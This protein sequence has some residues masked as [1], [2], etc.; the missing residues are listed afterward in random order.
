M[1]LNLNLFIFK[2][3]KIYP[4]LL[5]VFVVLLVGCNK[6]DVIE[7]NIEQKP[8][9][10]LD[11]EDGVYTVK[12]GHEL[13]IA[14]EYKNIDDAIITWTLDDRIVCRAPEWTATWYDAGE[15]FVTLT[16]FNDAGVAEEEIKVDVVELTPPVISLRLPSEGLKVVANTD[17]AI[18]PDIQHDDMDGFKIAWYVDNKLVSE[19]KEYTFHQS[20]LGTYH[21]KI[22][23][24]NIDGAT[25][26]EFDIQ[27][28][29]TMPYKVEFLTPSYFIKGTT[30]Y[31]F[32][33]RPVFLRPELEY[34]DDPVF[35]WS[36]DGLV[37]D[38]TTQMYEFT[39]TS[40]GEYIVTVTVR[41]GAGNRS[42][43]ITNNVSRAETSVTAEVKVVC[44]DATEEERMR[45][46]S[47]SSSLY[48]NKVYEYTPAPGQFIGETSA[49][50]GFTGNETT[51]ALAND[52]AEKRLAVHNYVSLGTFG[53]YVIVGF[54]HS[55]ER[56]GLEYDLAIEGNAFLS[57]QGGSNEPGIVWVMQDVNG[58]GLPDDEWYELKGCEYDNP[59]T[60]KN[61]AVTY[62]RP[63]APGMNVNWVDSEG[64]SGYVDYLSAYHTQPYYYPAW[65]TASTYTLHGTCIPSQ[66][67]VDPTTG[68]WNNANYA[69]GYVDNI[70]SDNLGGDAITGS[71]QRN[72]FKFS[73]A[74]YANGKTIGLKYV[75]FV[76]VQ[77]AVLAK[78]GALGEVSTE[79]FS[80]QDYS[81]IK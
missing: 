20:E 27:V 76:K 22:E 5:F 58:N 63:E 67:T 39:P 53:G 8:I 28:V 16:A 75:D 15:Y 44:V 51:I 48:S 73:N 35:E 45:P 49:I 69:W 52:W 36:V 33:N 24:E 56:T 60:I 42:R 43:A 59:K 74:V 62:Y 64:N 41:E 54:D 70:G 12:I 2:D 14:P 19:E 7:N 37:K 46:K 71:G 50:G 6:D 61:Y 79:V 65:I 10:T 32:A 9:I 18:A 81:M 21:V 77:V 80:F 1:C 47:A 23:A 13:T 30:R 25:V 29:E 78:S 72:G 34:F 55:I 17:Y 26:K 11:S 68:F 38:C 57:G 31:T 66:N 3:M 40:P 4:Y